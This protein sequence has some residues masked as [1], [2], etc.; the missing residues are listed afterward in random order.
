MTSSS[1]NNRNNW[2]YSYIEKSRGTRRVFNVINEVIKCKYSLE[3]LSQL[4]AFAQKNKW[5]LLSISENI[6]KYQLPNPLSQLSFESIKF[7]I[8]FVRIFP[9][10]REGEREVM[11]SPDTVIIQANRNFSTKSQVIEAFSLNNE[12][13]I[14][15]L[16]RDFIRLTL[17]QRLDPFSFLSIVES[18][19]I[20]NIG[21]PEFITFEP[22]TTQ[23]SVN[24]I[25]DF[26]GID[27]SYKR[28]TRG[29]D[30]I[31]EPI[32]GQYTVTYRSTGAE[33]PV[34]ALEDE[35]FA[36]QDI[37]LDDRLAIVD[38]PA[39][40]G[41]NTQLSFEELD[42][43]LEKLISFTLFRNRN[44]SII[45]S[46]FPVAREKNSNI[47]YF[48]PLECVIK[49]SRYLNGEQNSYELISYE[50]IRDTINNSGFSILSEIIPFCF[51]CQYNSND[52]ISFFKDLNLVIN[53]S[54]VIFAEPVFISFNRPET[55]FSRENNS[56]R[57]DNIDATDPELYRQWNLQA[58]N[59][60]DAWDLELGHPDIIQVILD[61]GV[62]LR[63]ID[64]EGKVL[65]R[66]NE[67]WNFLDRNSRSPQESRR[68]H[69]M[70]ISGIV[71][72]SHNQVNIA[73]CAPGCRIMPIKMYKLTLRTTTLAI[74]LNYIT[75]F[76]RRN[77]DKRFI[78]NMSF[79]VSDSE[80]VEQEINDGEL[81]NIIYVASAGNDSSSFPHF[82]SDYSKVISVAATAPRDI[83]SR[84][85]NFGQNVNICAPGGSG[86]PQLPSS[87]ILSLLPGD[88]IGTS[89]G[90]SL[91]APHVVAAAALILSIAK[92]NNRE[93]SPSSVRDIIYTT[94]D[95]IDA[96]NPGYEGQLGSG[97]LNVFSALIKTSQ[98]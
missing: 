32:L 75:S 35:G 83:I 42:E 7:E 46:M 70:L 64:I 17:P 44:E 56:T 73:G 13:G 59:N 71:N 4:R 18:N 62:D 54:Y 38:I 58:I 57:E 8:D 98:S 23:N 97:R 84:Y 85:S 76:A 1:E 45:L 2:E 15:I 40:S 52:Y 48:Q 39:I 19:S 28:K 94:A 21:E 20:I 27:L 86:E 37:S 80:I 16:R 68:R 5:K 14:E 11:V 67:D 34:D 12:Y 65:S 33:S 53:E 91:A 96:A 79:M 72:A 81:N 55:V 74:C 6:N 88:R 66:N 90:T 89:W 50:L 10:L 61:Q 47:T 9:A 93:I 26:L 31:F 25:F 24:K 95:N 49:F 43:V 36:V 30:A 22:Q 51:H 78:V 69:G 82:P 92:R 29:S 41:F 3:T 77:Q 63:H 87:N 60:L